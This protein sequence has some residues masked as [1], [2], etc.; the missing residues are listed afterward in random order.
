MRFRWSSVDGRKRCKNARVD[1]KLFI[2]FQETE[3]GGFRKRIS[4]DRALDFL[5]KNVSTKCRNTGGY[6][7]A[8]FEEANMAFKTECGERSPQ[9]FRKTNNSTCTVLN[10]FGNKIFSLKLLASLKIF[11]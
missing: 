6:F 9:Y 2:R 3:N 7:F 1:E 8:V 4:V 11:S 5:W 10:K